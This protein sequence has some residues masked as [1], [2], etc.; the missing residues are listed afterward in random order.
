[1]MPSDHTPS[2]LSRREREI[3]DVVY[4][5]DEVSVQEVCG[6]LT[7]PPS[8]SSVRT[9]MGILVDKGH[10]KTRKSGRKLL[11]APMHSRHQ[12]GRRSLRH[13]AATFFD[14]SVEQTVAC[15]LTSQEQDLDAAE[16]DRLQALI[17]QV[18]KEQTS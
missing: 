7:A 10:L 17:D 4:A 11:Y 18:R 9:I 5:R 8:Y 2:P 15:L 14:N 1:M 6:A 12:E 13:V 3:M 16:L